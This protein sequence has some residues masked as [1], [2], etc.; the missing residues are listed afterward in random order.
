MTDD[1]RLNQSSAAWPR[2]RAAR[3]LAHHAT[4]AD[5]LADFLDMLGLTAAEGRVS[6]PEHPE[7]EPTAHPVRLDEASACRLSHLLRSASHPTT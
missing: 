4:D 5:E 7:T 1:N 3:T 2:Y 6:P